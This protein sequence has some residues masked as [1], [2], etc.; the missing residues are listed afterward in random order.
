M[1]FSTIDK[2]D[3]YFCR[4]SFNLSLPESMERHK[5]LMVC[6]KDVCI[7]RFID[8]LHYYLKKKEKCHQSGTHSSKDGVD[9]KGG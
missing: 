7:G 6:V 2:N 4:E 3:I 8:I 1:N 5:Y 9:K